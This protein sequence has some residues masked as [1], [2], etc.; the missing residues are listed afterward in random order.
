MVTY[1][2]D[3][4]NKTTYY[5]FSTLN[6]SNENKQLVKSLVNLNIRE[7]PSVDTNILG[8]LKKDE[9][10]SL[11]ET[12]TFTNSIW[13]KIETND[14]KVGWVAGKYYNYTLAQILN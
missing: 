2:L 13:Y 3:G 1:Y 10:A 6:K 7:N 8:L 9:V 4:T 5:K 14:K 12:K 11:L